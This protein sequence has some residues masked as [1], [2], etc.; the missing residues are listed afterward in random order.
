MNRS[1]TMT[2]SSP[3]ASNRRAFIYLRISGQYDARE[4]SLSTQ[5]EAC[6]KEASLLGYTIL[7]VY[8]ERHTGA[9]LNERKEMTAMRKRV[10]AGE[11]D[12]IFC[13]SIDRLSRNQAHVW[14]I[15]DEIR[16]FAPNEGR[17][18]CYLEKFE[19]N[20]TGK[21]ILS[22]HAFRAE[23]EREYIRDR[24]M[25]GQRNK[26]SRGVL[27]AAGGNLFGYRFIQEQSGSKII[28]T[29]KRQIEPGEAITI[30]RIF[31]LVANEGMSARRASEELNKQIAL[32]P[33][34]SSSLNKSYQ[35]GRWTGSMVLAIIHNP[36]Y[37]GETLAQ[38]RRINSKTRKAELRPPEEVIVLPEGVTPA[39]INEELWQ[40]ANDVLQ[41]NRCNYA[42]N[43]KDFVDLRGMVWCKRC[44][45]NKQKRSKCVVT[46]S[47]KGKGRR[48]HRFRC[49]T[50]THHSSNYCGAPSVSAAWLST[51][52][53]EVLLEWL[54]EPAAIERAILD[55]KRDT[56]NHERLKS[57]RS[58]LE[59]KVAE[60]DRQRQRTARLLIELPDDEDEG[61]LRRQMDSLR[62][63]RAA[64]LDLI[65]ELDAQITAAFNASPDLV[66]QEQL[67]ALLSATEYHS[68][69]M[70]AEVM[71]AIG[72]AVH[73]DG[74][75]FYLDIP[76]AGKIPKHL[77][78][79]ITRK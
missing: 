74:R 38:K 48:F 11:V 71:R 17:L 57:S 68:P 79:P 9:E 56:G 53:W 1:E 10:R 62:E 60:I 5:E 47:S 37:K 7:D 23:A 46:T 39:I 55:Q 41:S 18:I 3:P 65:K 34:P 21:L 50:T 40:R 31:S 20:P 78:G 42:R 45:E 72:L 61:P 77:P 32:H 63:G 25:R 24:T 76:L 30:R 12:A 28:H 13:Y 66:T 14:I 75:D 16:R 2:S 51:A 59:A 49:G 54:R 70:R 4:A 58:E 52:V 27:S 33:T 69:E 19:D 64:Q 43:E 35:A 44:D 67:T 15:Y 26:I 6:R 36:A 73:A 29:G 22:I 8:T